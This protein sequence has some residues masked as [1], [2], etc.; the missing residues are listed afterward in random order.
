MRTALKEN[1]HDVLELLRIDDKLIDALISKECF[2]VTQLESV[3]T[4]SPV[5][6]GVRLLDMIKRSSIATYNRFVQ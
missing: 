3:I 5:E 1:Y 2:T 4:G 6:R